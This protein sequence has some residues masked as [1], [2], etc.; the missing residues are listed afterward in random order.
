MLD[1][2]GA[3]NVY[4][5][6]ALVVPGLLIVWARAQF[7]TGRLQPVKDA[8]VAYLALSVV[9]YA[10]AF[11]MV[12]YALTF[13]R[14][15][16]PK[17]L[18]W[19]A[20]VF[21][22]PLATGAML[23]IAAQREWLRALAAKLG[24]NPVHATPTAWDFTFADRRNATFV[25]ATLADGSTVSGLFGTGSFASS[26]PAERDLLIEE[27][28]DVDDAGLWSPKPERI[29]IYLTAKEIRHVQFWTDQGE[30]T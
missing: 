9:Y 8:A 17:A 6:L 24:I 20:I 14:P 23:G 13:E 21:I 18:A 15:G 5:V 2:K 12:E 3:A 4:L 22:G 11:P 16:W 10:L 30:T 7:I 19:L 27:V 26:D 29:A 1:L 25:M 28:W